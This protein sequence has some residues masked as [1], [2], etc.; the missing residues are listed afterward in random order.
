MDGRGFG[1]ESV[2]NM[3]MYLNIGNAGFQSVRKG[4][5]VDKSGLI[6]F[7]NGT[8][9]TDYEYSKH[10]RNQLSDNNIRNP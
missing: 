7:M 1:R 9:G 10:I 2:G 6:S 3:G 8:L 5:Y 4:F